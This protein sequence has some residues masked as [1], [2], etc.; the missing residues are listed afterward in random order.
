MS[1]KKFTQDYIKNPETTTYKKLIELE[2]KFDIQKGD[3]GDKGDKPIAGIDYEIPKDGKTP[4]KGIDYFDGENG[5]DGI[6]GVDGIDGLNGRDGKDGSPDT[7]NQIADKLN[8]LTEKVEIKV[9]RDLEKRLNEK[10]EEVIK[11]IPKNKSVER[12][13][14]MVAG[15][16]GASY[17]TQLN[18]TPSEY[19]GEANKLVSVKADESGLE[20]SSGE[21]I[22]DP[23]Y[24]RRD[25]TLPLTDDWNAGSYRITSAGFTSSENIILQDDKY[26]VFDTSGKELLGYSSNHG[27]L[28][29]RNSDTEKGVLSASGNLEFYSNTGATGLGNWE[30]QFYFDEN[31]YAKIKNT[32]QGANKL[33][34]IE[35]TDGIKYTSNGNIYGAFI[36]AD[37][38]ATSDKTFQFPNLSGTFMLNVVEDTTPQ[39]GG[40]LDCQENAID[41]VGDITHDDATASDWI[42]RNEDQDKFTRFFGN[43]GGSDTEL[44]T[45][46]H[47][48]GFIGINNSTPDCILDLKTEEDTDF[49]MA[50][51]SDDV[52]ALDLTLQK[53]R[54]SISSPS[55]ALS[56]DTAATFKGE[57]W[58]GSAWQIIGN[59][60]FGCDGIAA[61]KYAGKWQL[62]LADTAG[63]VSTFLVAEGSTS[64][65]GV[66]NNNPQS[67]LDVS[68]DITG[69]GLKTTKGR[70]VKVD[71]Y[72]TNQ[73]LTIDNDVVKM[74][75][76][77]GN[78]IVYLPAGIE[79]HRLRICNTGNSGNTL[80][81][82]PNG[83]EKIK[84]SS[85]FILYDNEDLAVAY[86][87]TDGWD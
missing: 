42:F 38:I 66:N 7:P 78:L 23:I 50:K 15:G 71:R 61:G 80:T 17:F 16:G 83:S 43:D 41:N 84:N 55:A 40:T 74:N 1:K 39:L 9:I 67:T 12:Y 28:L 27:S 6:N 48:Q 29:L 65:F 10:K 51:Y 75:T 36:K 21:I 70:I 82:T 58:T 86:D 56:T 26:L 62:R 2:D 54:G 59:F 30:P 3:K 87:N 77:G 22:L 33:F 5:K 25:G 4:I 76:D 31:G 34:F 69:E 44:L 57:L 52:L 47:A 24:I 81:I 60:R 73:T 37:N 8:T 63:S 19:T 49:C 72:T 64:R 46:D 32:T 53:A 18:D 20:F 35:F 13:I 11:E 79:G 14:Q 85:S 45:F 68:G